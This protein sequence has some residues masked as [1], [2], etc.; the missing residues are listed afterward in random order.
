MLLAVSLSRHPDIAEAV[1]ELGRFQFA[2]KRIDKYLSVYQAYEAIE[3]HPQLELSVVR[4][5]LTHAAAALSRPKTVAAL[6]R[7]FGTTDIDLG[8]PRHQKVFYQQLAILLVTT[9]S[10]LADALAKRMGELYV[11]RDGDT[12]FP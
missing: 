7:L 1:I 2:S 5:A 6:Q 10:L 11:L 9:E 8:S 3:E 4:H 12:L